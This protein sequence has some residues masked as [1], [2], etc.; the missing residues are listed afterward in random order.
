M[1]SHRAPQDIALIVFH[2]H[3]YTRFTRR[4]WKHM[5]S[6]PPLTNGPRYFM[7]HHGGQ[8]LV[9]GL[10]TSPVRGKKPYNGQLPIN[11]QKIKF[12][13]DKGHR[14]RGYAKK[15]FPLAALYE[16][17]NIGC[18]KLDA[19]WM[20]RY[21]SWEL[22][23]ATRGTFNKIALTAVL[24]HHFDNHEHCVGWCKAKGKIGVEK[25]KSSLRFRS[26][27]RNAGM[28]NHF[29]VLHTE[30]ME[31]YQLRQLFHCWDANAIEGFNKLI[32]EFLPKDR[33]TV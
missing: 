8:G 33:Y 14:I 28:Y 24:E 31:E 1:P 13:A 15:F 29:K 7:F 11:H 26:K 6:S 32:T 16:E 23:I 21:T 17:K 25:K 22:R 10:L 9:S 5:Y 20:K 2:L 18:K 4:S 30:F 3:H 27:T 19:A 12:L